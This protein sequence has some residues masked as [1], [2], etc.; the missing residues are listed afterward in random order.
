MSMEMETNRAQTCCFTGH[1][2]LQSG[3]KGEIVRKLEASVAALI[4]EG[5]R[6]FCAGGALGFDTLAAQTVLALRQ[7]YPEIKLILVL[8]C[9]SQTKGWPAADKAVYQRIMERADEVIYVSREYTKGC[10]HQ[11]NCALVDRSSAC[12]CYRTRRTGGTTYTVR[13]AEEQGLRIWNL[14]EG[15]MR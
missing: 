13:Y 10:M 7:I 11:R 9:V 5:Y 8:P 6:F 4:E 12:I 14:A 3:R 1:R 15:E 2:K